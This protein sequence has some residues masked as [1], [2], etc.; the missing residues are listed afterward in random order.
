LTLLAK[1]ANNPQRSLKIFLSGLG[2]F[3]SGAAAIFIGY[4]HHH[5]W[6]I[7]GL[8]LLAVGILFA[9]WGYVGIFAQRLSQMFNRYQK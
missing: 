7:L 2:L 5:Y 8:L 3:A 9:A 1:L 4:Y 6:Q